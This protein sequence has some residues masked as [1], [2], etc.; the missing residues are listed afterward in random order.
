MLSQLTS[1]QLLTNSEPGTH[2][3]FYRC[4]PCSTVAKSA[5]AS[6]PEQGLSLISLQNI[7]QHDVTA[8]EQELHKLSYIYI[9]L[10]AYYR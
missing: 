7:L 6:A 9:G 2:E 5:Y 1:M 10:Q 8:K 4:N 3:H